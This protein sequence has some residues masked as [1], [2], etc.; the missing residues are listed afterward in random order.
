MRGGTVFSWA[1]GNTVCSVCKRLFTSRQLYYSYHI[2]ST[3]T[4]SWHVPLPLAPVAD[5]LAR[6]QRHQQEARATAVHCDGAG[7]VGAAGHHADHVVAADAAVIVASIAIAITLIL[8][9]DVAHL[10]P[11]VNAVP[12]D[13]QGA[14]GDDRD[15]VVRVVTGFLCK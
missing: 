4:A 8:V 11:G 2:I 3:L 15:G 5:P 7:L 12:V 14:I 10:D 6:R 9:G 13:L 1:T